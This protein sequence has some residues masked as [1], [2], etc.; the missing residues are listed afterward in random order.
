MT[1]K[2]MAG[3]TER[4]GL[5]GHHVAV[6]FVCFFALVIAV[7]VTMAVLASRTFGGLVV[8]NSYVASQKFN[9]WLARARDES[10]L[11]WDMTVA[12][13]ANGR[14]SLALASAGVPMV[15]ARITGR[16]RH[17]LGRLPERVIAF[18]PDGAGRYASIERLPAGRWIVHLDI[19]AHGRTLRKIVDLQ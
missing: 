16:A 2:T 7:N 8:E 14:L 13:A 6:I 12:R 15:D 5:T 1:D 18:Q 19:A 10:A 9:E 17:P 11:G 4:K 3:E